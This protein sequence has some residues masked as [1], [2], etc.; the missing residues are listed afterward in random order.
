MKRE[1]QPGWLVDEA[2]AQVPLGCGADDAGPD[3]VEAW[4]GAAGVKLFDA[5]LGTQ[6]EFQDE[7]TF[8]VRVARQPPRLVTAADHV[9]SGANHPAQMLADKG[10]ELGVGVEAAAIANVGVGDVGE[11]DG[12]GLLRSR[13]QALLIAEALS[14]QGLE[15]AVIPSADD[16]DAAAFVDRVTG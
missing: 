16:A 8:L 7:A 1:G 2:I 12:I 10:I 15:P 5:A 4:I 9:V 11:G 6:R 13:Q 3:A 14:L